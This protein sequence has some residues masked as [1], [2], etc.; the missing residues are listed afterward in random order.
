MTIS[1]L[2]DIRLLEESHIDPMSGL[3]STYEMIAN[4]A[5]IDPGSIA[6]SFFLRS[7]DFKT[8]VTWTYADLLADITRAANMFRRL[9]VDR[10]DV[11]A[12][13]LPNLPETHIALWGAETAGI[14]F[15]V[16][17]LLDGSQMGQLLQAANTRWIVTV[18]SNPDP[19]IW[20]RV[21][22]AAES[23]TQLRGLLCI[24]AL[25]HLPGY[26]G[27]QALPTT[28]DNVPVLDFH[29]ELARESGDELN[30]TPPGPEDIAAYFCT[31]G[32]TGLPKIAQ[33]T[34]RNETS[35]AFQVKTF[36]AGHIV[37]PG[38]TVLTALPLF[39]ANAQLGTGL[40]IFA[41]GGH[42]LLASADGYRTPG[43]IEH[44]WEII[45]HHRVASFSGVP[46]VYAGL[47][48]T[49]RTGLD[50][51]CLNRAICG[52]APMPVDLFRNFEKE[53]GVR[54]LE[55][56]GLTEGTCVASINP[57]DGESRI[58]SIGIRV[59]WQAMCTMIVDNNGNFERLAAS[60][61]VGAICLSGPN[62]FPGYL[63][64]GQNRDIWIDA[65][66][67]DGIRRRWLNTGDLG[68]CD[69]DGY[70]WLTGRK[71]ELI[72]RGGHNID[73]KTIEEV[74]AE[75]PA[76]AMAA[77]VGRPDPRL[78]EIPVAYVQ[79]RAGLDADASSLL[80]FA[81]EHISERAA[82]PKAINIVDAL[83]VTAVG[84]TFKP[85]LSM[86]EIESVVRAEAE[87]AGAE[88]AELHVEQDA[89]SGF[90]AYYRVRDPDSA[91]ATALGTALGRYTFKI[92]STDPTL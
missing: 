77:A 23:L 54:I 17:P 1:S 66:G 33:H 48:Q 53:T 83:P 70:F 35:N 52:A 3:G 30:F 14:A 51:A 64:P 46:T 74:L 39:H 69:A 20:K 89:K 65:A 80:K 82:A 34:H 75:H 67:P 63:N 12:Y 87:A 86:W 43:L 76:V 2:R 15:A 81:A 7:E 21:E 61:E 68:R 22:S 38:Q 84:K 72:I 62:I 91:G 28:L 19:E 47:L 41:G 42:V 18:G 85:T 29:R 36:V 5:A 49:P 55:A 27:S 37:A 25:K 58:G 13:I 16:N 31:G 10:G 79:L 92:S 8:P 59:P 57:P 45:E 40:A 71:K 26:A 32:T 4:G 11:V 44:F 56:Y 9:G 90:V 60:D 6:L 78:G 73:P 50:L 88:L 24:D